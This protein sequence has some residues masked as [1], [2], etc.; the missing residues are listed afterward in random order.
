MIDDNLEVQVGNQWS[1]FEI[2][3]V[4][5]FSSFR[6]AAAAFVRRVRYVHFL[7]SLCS[8]VL[9]VSVEQVLQIVYQP[10]AVFRIKP[11]TRCSASIPGEFLAQKI[12]WF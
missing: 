9:A 1:A 3:G 11:V 7:T 12:I 4:P 2:L 5:P 6:C 8:V 10:Q